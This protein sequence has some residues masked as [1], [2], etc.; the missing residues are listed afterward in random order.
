M[1]IPDT[2]LK[3]IFLNISL[4]LIFTEHEYTKQQ[5]KHKGRKNF[6]E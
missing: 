1:P 6:D 4:D 2:E 3:F 5:I